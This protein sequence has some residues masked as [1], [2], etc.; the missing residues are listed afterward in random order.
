MGPRHLS[1]RNERLALAGR[2]R[3]PGRHRLPHRLRRPQAPARP[4]LLRRQAPGAAADGLPRL[5]RG[6]LGRGT[7]WPRGHRGRRCRHCRRLR[8]LGLAPPTRDP[9]LP[10]AAMAPPG[11]HGG[12]LPGALLRLGGFPRLRPPYQ[13]HRAAHGLRPPQ[14]RGQGVVLPAR[15][16]VAARL[17][18]QLLLLWLSMHGAADQAH[19]SIIGGDL[20]PLAGPGA[21]HGRRGSPWPGRQPALQGRGDPAHGLRPR[22]PGGGPPGPGGQRRGRSGAR[23]SP[24]L[25]VHGLLGVGGDQGVAGT[26]GG[27]LLVPPRGLVVVAGHQGHRHRG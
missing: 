10:E 8:L 14:Q 21:R 16:P 19:R 12:R 27:D 6:L 11:C 13:P 20:Q 25:R 17:C 3:G 24:G 7:G 5:A 26:G 22:P 1:W 18:R 9:V 15:G 2:H 4:G 23:E